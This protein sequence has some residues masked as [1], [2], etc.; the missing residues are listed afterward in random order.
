MIQPS[1]ALPG[2][3]PIAVAGQLWATLR[4]EL[5]M[6]WR[7]WGFWLAFAAAWAVILFILFS[8]GHVLRHLDTI[9]R[10]LSVTPTEIVN[11]YVDANTLYPILLFPIIGSLLVTDRMERDRRLG[12]AELQRAAPQDTPVFVL[13]KFL[14]N[15][16][17]VLLP[18]FVAYTFFSIVMLVL[19]APVALL[20]TAFYA[21]VLV[22]LPSLAVMIALTLLLSN[23]LPL[24]IVQIG[25][26]LLWLYSTRSPL[27]WHTIDDTI[28]NP[29]GRYVLPVFFPS[30][31]EAVHPSG[32]TI[33]LA[34]LNIT[35]LLATA[36]VCLI[37]LVVS[38]LMQAR[39]ETS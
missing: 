14:G 31:F 19:G 34:W 29:R 4:A 7:R 6:Q 17:A 24:R 3:G 1:L 27:G 26:P 33:Q 35:V 28:F 30:P 8:N 13:G 23:V 37:L 36:L 16:I 22:F 12:M 39:A 5:L 15:Y 38:L 2:T 32:Y 21:F 9:F 10:G 20:P 25:F 18:T 11:Y